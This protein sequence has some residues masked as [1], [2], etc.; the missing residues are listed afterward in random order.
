MPFATTTT[1]KK[2]KSLKQKTFYSLTHSL[3][4]TPEG[5]QGKSAWV[6]TFLMMM[7]VREWCV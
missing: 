6:S 1:P 5:D 2:E 7:V 3:T 4:R